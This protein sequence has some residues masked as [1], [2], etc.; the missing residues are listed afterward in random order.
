MGLP[1]NE[2]LLFQIQL[3]NKS[4]P[5]EGLCRPVRDFLVLVYTDGANEAADVAY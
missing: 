1:D 2:I 3:S 5:G 4:G